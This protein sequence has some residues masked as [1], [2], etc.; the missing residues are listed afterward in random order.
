MIAHDIKLRQKLKFKPKVVDQPIVLT[1]S[2]SIVVLTQWRENGSVK[3][4]TN[5]VVHI[6]VAW[7]YW[8]LY[9]CFF[10]LRLLQLRLCI[11]HNDPF[12]RTS[13]HTILVSAIQSLFVSSSKLVARY[14]AR[15]LLDKLTFNCFYNQ[16]FCYFHFSGT[17]FRTRAHLNISAFGISF[18]PIGLIL[19]K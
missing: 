11:A 7:W 12:K 18:S 9:I 14:S 4:Q 5:I 19:K 17:V 10:S 3:P 8:A 16:N 15:N 2:F 13:K 6:V 1:I